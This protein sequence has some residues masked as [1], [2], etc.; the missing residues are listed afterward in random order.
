MDGGGY[1]ACMPE[2]SNIEISVKF[3]HSIDKDQIA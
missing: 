2:A 1:E 3:G